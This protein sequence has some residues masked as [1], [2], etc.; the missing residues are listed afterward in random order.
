M[1]D[2]KNLTWTLIGLFFL[3]LV[4]RL[5]FLGRENLW[6]DEATT[7][8]IAS[9]SVSEIYHNRWDPHPPLYYLFMHY[10][11]YLGQRDIIV[12]LPSVLLGALAVPLLFSLGRLLFTESAA[13]L[14]ALTLAVSPLP[15]WYAQETRMYTLVGLCALLSAYF[16]VLFIRGVGRV[17]W[18]G[19][20][21]VTAIGLYS[22]YTM[23]LLVLALNTFVIAY[24]LA[25]PKSCRPFSLGV[26]L[27]MQLAVLLLYTPWL[28]VLPRHLQLIRNTTSYPLW[29]LTAPS[30]LFGFVIGGVIIFVGLV[31]W[32]R[33]P[34]LRFLNSK[35][36]QSL[37]AITIAFFLLLYFGLMFLALINRMTTLTRQIYITIPFLYLGLAALFVHLPRWHYWAASLLAVS[38][39]GSVVSGVVIQKPPWQEIVLWI[40]TQAAPGDVIVFSP[41]WLQTPF[42]RY[43]QKE[44]PLVGVQLRQLES[45]M[46]FLEEKYERAWVILSKRDIRWFDPEQAVRSW[47]YAHYQVESQK[48]FGVMEIAHFTFGGDN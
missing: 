22:H 35:S 48:E 40:S 25:S 10:W 36:R 12:R 11:L 4:L 41:P 24:W 27:L 8:V 45:Q 29:F 3:A 32:M 16:C 23:G 31:I 15:I 20:I 21:L 18:M 38:I 39:F 37:Y 19:Y 17:N 9:K 42:R 33:D 7:L 26:W 2:K 34:K 30:I 43:I 44:M 13:W 14:A 1:K 28:P 5:T 47:F 6:L 46:T